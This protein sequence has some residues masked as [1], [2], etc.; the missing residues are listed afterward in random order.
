MIVWFDDLQT[1]QAKRA[2]ICGA[3]P[4]DLHHQKHGRSKK[5]WVCGA[6][7]DCETTK[8]PKGYTY[9]YLWQFSLHDTEFHGRTVSS[10]EVFAAL[11]DDELQKA[12][13]RKTHGKIKAYPQLLIYDANFGY[14]YSFFQCAFDRLGVVKPFAKETRHPLTLNV[15][16]C[17]EFREA[18]GVWGYSLENIGELWTETKKAVGDLRYDLQRHSLTPITEQEQVYTRNDVRILSELGRIALEMYKGRQIPITGTGIIRQATKERTL[19]AGR[20]SIEFEKEKV[21]RIMPHN[22]QDYDTIMNLLYCGGLTHS[23]VTLARQVHQNVV[24]ADLVSDFSAQ[25][26]HE[27]FPAGSLIGNRSYEEMIKHK[28]WYALVTFHNLKTKTHHSIIS[29]HKCVDLYHPTIDNGRIY[30]AELCSVYCTEVD[31]QN[32]GLIYTCDDVEFSDM[33]IFTQSRPC[34]P[35]LLSVMWEKYEEKT[36]LKPLQKAAETALKA[37]KDSGDDAAIEQAKKALQAV[38]KAYEQ[39]KKFVNGCYGMTST[40][41][42]KT[43]I[44]WGKKEGMEHN[45][46]YEDKRRDPNDGHELTYAEMTKDLWLSPW[47]AIYTTAYAR[48]I[49][50]RLINKYPDII[51]Q[52]DTDSIY[53]LDGRTGSEDLRREMEEYNETMRQKNAEMFAGNPMFSD[54][55]TWEFDP[56]IDEMKVLGAK[57]Y[58]KRTGNDYKLV[59][60]GCKPE[61]FNAYCAEKEIDPFDFFDKNMRLPPD[62]SKKTTL[63]YFPPKDKPYVDTITDYLGNTQQVEIETCAT[64]TEV[65]FNLWVSGMW[66]DFIKEKQKQL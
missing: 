13:R 48:R 30:A 44:Y 66:I 61:A 57:R 12:Y 23:N 6:G 60:A 54:L 39:S 51:L 41:I 40:R 15:R 17:L 59:C 25:M 26:T 38:K 8:T 33:H 5:Y 50:C 53:Y 34:P 7:F 20:Y 18:L 2:A 63:R 55:G 3:L 19:D 58:L 47:I 31:F 45:G 52:Y 10:F 49:L 24:C 29:Q 16:R 37:A 22:L 36:R 64:I 14:E 62:N 56:P 21:Q 27:Q 9:V 28:H 42:Y 35:A 65:P 11:L 46:L 1:D 43:E 32:I 4:P